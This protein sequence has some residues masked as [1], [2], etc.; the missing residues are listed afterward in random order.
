MA[1][2]KRS[3]STTVD[4]AS[5]VE[6]LIERLRNEGVASGQAKAEQIVQALSLIHI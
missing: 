2:G 3:R 4:A 6:A 5:G 1:A